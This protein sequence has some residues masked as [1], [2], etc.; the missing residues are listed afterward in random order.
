MMHGVA[1]AVQHPR[2]RVF[3]GVNRR[4]DRCG[5]APFGEVWNDLVRGQDGGLSERAANSAGDIAS[6]RG[7][8]DRRVPEFASLGFAAVRSVHGADFSG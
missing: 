1:R 6:V 7:R 3:G 4:V 8:E 2:S 5:I